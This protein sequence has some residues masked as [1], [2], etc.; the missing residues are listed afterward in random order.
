MQTTL[1][2]KVID[3][4]EKEV[5]DLCATSKPSILRTTDPLALVSVT[6]SAVCK[7]LQERAPTFYTMLETITGSQKSKTSKDNLLTITSGAA[8]ILKGRNMHMSAWAA[9][10][11]LTLEHGGCSTMAMKRLAK[12]NVTVDPNTTRARK[13]VLAKD[14]DKVILEQKETLEKD[15]VKEMVVNELLTVDGL[16]MEH[17]QSSRQGT[18]TETE[19][20]VEQTTHVPLQIQSRGLDTDFLPSLAW[21]FYV[22]EN[23]DKDQ[24]ED[25]RI[26]ER[27]K[28]FEK[29]YAGHFGLVVDEVISHSQTLEC[30]TLLRLK[31]AMRDSKSAGYQV[32]GDNVDLLIKARHMSSERQNKDIHWFF[33]YAAIDEV[34]G[35]HLD[36]FRMPKVSDVPLTKC[37][38][39]SFDVKKLKYH[40]MVLWSRVVV[41]WI[42]A[43][44]CLS[45]AVVRHIPHRY[46]NT[47]KAKTTTVPLGLLCKNE[48]LP[49][50]MLF[51]LKH[52]Q[53]RYVPQ[54]VNKD[55]KN[56]ILEQIFFG[57]DNL[58]VERAVNAQRAS[59]DGD[60][61][62]E[63]LQGIVAKN[64]DWHADRNKFQVVW[65]SNATVTNNANAK[66]DPL[67]N[68]TKVKEPFNLYLDV[69]I[70]AAT[71]AYLRLESIEENVEIVPDKIKSASLDD[72]RE[73]LHALIQPMIEQFVLPSLSTESLQTLSRSAE[74]PKTYECPLCK[75]SYKYQ[76][77]LQNHMSKQHQETA[78]S[79]PAETEA[80]VEQEDHIFNYGCVFIT[81]GLMLRNSDDA[82][83]EGDGERIISMWKFFLP[84]WKNEGSTKYALSALELFLTLYGRLTE[85]AA[86][87]LIW[88]RT[89]NKKGGKGKRISRDFY[90]ENLN[91]VL[92]DSFKH[93][94]VNINEKTAVLESQ[95]L[96]GIDIILNSQNQ[97]LG[98]KKPSGYHKRVR[99]ELDF[100]I[101][102]NE[103]VRKCD[104]FNVVVGREFHSFPSFNRSIL[105]GL[106][107]TGFIKWMKAHKRKLEIEDEV[108]SY[109]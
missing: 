10:N 94:G 59:L 63:R 20:S 41:H 75:K 45:K 2:K 85:Q 54:R 90:I 73:W 38:P 92:K 49:E 82:V 88:N 100:K 12:Q 101:V 74:E 67:E 61:P 9:K 4:V 6:P 95:A 77:A 26:F 3:K 43:L 83:K 15:I 42:P 51:I 35:S 57:G 55:K 108:R 72:Q 25:T 37:L 22:P 1:S 87:R 105:H 14:H 99:S 28:D 5:V 27:L 11:S 107:H 66:L 24:D 89:I 40:C 91:L 104:M 53:D 29:D 33:M 109:V 84:I 56:E 32:I 62:W 64:E 69:Y 97:D 106:D 102:L 58:T 93:L 13:K 48:N 31:K 79:N 60:S 18:V 76:G 96:Y 78:E 36:N 65:F 52:V 21:S 34:S 16:T 19:G 30:D 81:L 23:E 70:V 98:L 44:Q 80:T 50:D 17:L 68:Y 71:M 8:V 47:M 7:E 46:E 86:H 39:N 103:V